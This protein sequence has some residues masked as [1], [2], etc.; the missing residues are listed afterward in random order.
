MGG[1]QVLSLEGFKKRCADAISAGLPFTA[2]WH[3]HGHFFLFHERE[4]DTWD[5]RVGAFRPKLHK[6]SK[7]ALTGL[8]KEINKMRRD[9]HVVN[10][11]VVEFDGI[12]VG[13]DHDDLAELLS[14]PVPE[15]EEV[16]K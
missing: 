15:R 4:L 1:T 10:L 3:A 14:V 8:R 2:Y 5:K 13:V 11:R 16:V 9:P 6:A 7:A 12:G